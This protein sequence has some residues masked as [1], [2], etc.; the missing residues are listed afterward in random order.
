MQGNRE[1]ADDALGNALVIGLLVVV[2]ALAFALA[3]GF[4]VARP[5]LGDI[6]VFD[7]S[8]HHSPDA[9]DTDIQALV[10]DENRGVPRLRSCTLRTE[11]MMAVG[12]SLVVE[13]YEP[14]RRTAYQVHWAGGPTAS[15]RSDCGTEANLFVTQDDLSALRAAADGLDGAAT[16]QSMAALPGWQ[17]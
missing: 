14:R 8:R 11:T 17:G 3:R 6:I 4:I 9:Q 5:S 7:P 10:A 12:G 13:A 15:G 1:R 2:V 16:P